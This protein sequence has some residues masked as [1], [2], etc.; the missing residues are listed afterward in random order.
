M[1]NQVVYAKN[2]DDKE[3]KKD[4]LVF[5]PKVL[6]QK[7]KVLQSVIFLWRQSH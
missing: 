4:S 5:Y 2:S 3:M 7:E 6:L 1:Y